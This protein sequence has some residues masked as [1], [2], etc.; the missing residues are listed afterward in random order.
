MQNGKAALSM[1]NY[2]KKKKP[3]E[4]DFQKLLKPIFTINGGTSKLSSILFGPIFFLV[5]KPKGDKKKPYYVPGAGGKP[6][7]RDG[8]AKFFA[9][10][11]TEKEKSTLDCMYCG[12]NGAL[13]I[14]SYTNPFITKIAKFPNAY[15]WGHVK[16]LALC[17]DCSLT[18]LAANNRLI[19]KSN[20]TKSKTDFISMLMFFSKMKMIL[21]LFTKISLTVQLYQNIIEIQNFFRNQ[22]QI[23]EDMTWFGILKN[24]LWF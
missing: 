12:K 24:F 14:P 13:E 15:S 4:K 22:S 1:I 10:K 3:T 20:T 8:Y 5:A 9:N 18:G 11:L 6:N 7:F 21:V 16:S 2:N 23:K 19:F 17:Q